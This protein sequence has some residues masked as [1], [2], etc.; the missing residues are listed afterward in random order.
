MG[1]QLG[2]FLKTMGAASGVVPAMVASTGGGP[3]SSGGSTRETLIRWVTAQAQA[4]M[5]A[6]VG[7]KFALGACYL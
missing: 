3:P 7:S 1:R 2:Q 6:R 4:V 5:A